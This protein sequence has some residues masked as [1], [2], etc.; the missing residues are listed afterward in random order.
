MIL[1]LVDAGHISSVPTR[2][3]SLITGSA[4][5]LDA[6]VW[7]TIPGWGS[8]K[9][10]IVIAWRKRR[11]TICSVNG[12]CLAMSAN[13]TRPPGGIIAAMLNLTIAC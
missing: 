8:Q 6:W 7:A 5:N 3:Q 10:R 4:S 2:S 1:A 12:V 9:I 13:D 11:V